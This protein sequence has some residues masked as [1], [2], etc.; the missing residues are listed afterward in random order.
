MMAEALESLVRYARMKLAEE[1]KTVDDKTL[2]VSCAGLFLPW[3]PGPFKTGDIRTDGKTPYECMQDHDS[4]KNPDWDISVR[5]LWKPYHS[6]AKEWALPF[7]HPT[8]AY[9]TYNT[10]EFM[11]YTDGKVYESLIDGNA[12]SPEEYAKGWSVA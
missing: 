4:T 11:V 6:K 2:D 1:S 12:Y 9:D 3:T 5:T 10:G 7:I 8:G